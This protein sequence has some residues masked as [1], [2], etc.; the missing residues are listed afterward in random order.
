MS[1]YLRHW[2]RVLAHLRTSTV[3]VLESGRHDL[4]NIIAGLKSHCRTGGGCTNKRRVLGK[5]RASAG[6]VAAK[7]RHAI[8][9]EHL[10][11]R[12]GTC[13]IAANLESVAAIANAAAAHAF[14]SNG[15]EVL[16]LHVWGRAAHHPQWWPSAVYADSADK[17]TSHPHPPPCC[18]V[19]QLPAA[20]CPHAPPTRATKHQSTRNI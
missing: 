10:K 15:F 14:A 7:L 11:V 4:A 18:P 1:N 5:Y 19:A 9:S 6:E 2:E 3:L 17:V 8:D 16:P 20:C 13:A 12:V